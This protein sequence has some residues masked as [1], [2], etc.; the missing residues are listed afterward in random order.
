M[1]QYMWRIKQANMVR[2]F[3]RAVEELPNALFEIFD[4]GI[5]QVGV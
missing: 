3:G 4:C 1:K 5:V 2:A